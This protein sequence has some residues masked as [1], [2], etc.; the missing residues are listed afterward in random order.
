MHIH[1]SVCT[2]VYIPLLFFTSSLEYNL[3]DPG[4]CL[5]C[6]LFLHFGDVTSI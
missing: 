1:I 4:F 5:L 2:C 3:Q 6:T